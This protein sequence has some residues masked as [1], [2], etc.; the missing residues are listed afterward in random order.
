MGK[1]AVSKKQREIDR[2]NGVK[3]CPTCNTKKQFSEYGKNATKVDG[4]QPFCKTCQKSKALV[5]RY[6]LTESGL[7]FLLS[8][9]GNNCGMC[10]EALVDDWCV[11][12]DH[13]CCAGYKS[14][15]ACVRGI[16]CGPC[17]RGLGHFEKF[18]ELAEQY[19]FGS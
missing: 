16:L 10:D 14:C 3:T 18:R 6:G 11:D 17:N 8:K 1:H 19:L 9:Q 15:G 4:L 13:S 2:A 7:N 5:A 12:H